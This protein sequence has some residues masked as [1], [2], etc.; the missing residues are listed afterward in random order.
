MMTDKLKT[1]LKRIMIAIVVVGAAT[2]G[3]LYYRRSTKPA[4]SA[5]QNFYKVA[6]RKGNI[7]VNV[8]A[9]G[10]VSSASVQ[11][12]VA[13]SSGTLTELKVSEGSQVKK[14]DVIA[15]IDDD[16][17]SQEIQK[18]ENDLKQQNINL[19]K[20]KDSLNDFYIK[21]PADGRVKAIKAKVGEDSGV[22]TK[23]YG[24]LAIIST[25]GKMKLSIKTDDQIS[26][27]I[28]EK[29][30]VTPDGAGS[31]EGT[32]EDKEPGQGNTIVTVTI[33]RDDLAIG[34][35]ASVAKADGTVVG[36]GTLQVNSPVNVSGGNGVISKIYVSENA[37]IKRGSKM[38]KLKDTDVQASIQS[39]NLSINQIKEE[40]ENKKAKLDELEVIA[41]C[42]GIVTALSIKAGDSVQEGKA[43]ATITDPS[44]LQVVAAVDE[45]DIS[46]VQVGQKAVITLNALPDKSFEGSVVKI[47][48]IGNSTNNVT[49][50]DVTV[51]VNNPENIK[52]GMSAN[53]QIQVA[54]KENV[55]LLP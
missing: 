43:I 3:Y 18:L 40:L 38:F 55:L 54:S 6:A 16:T 31:I 19:N 5:Q 22:T 15:V 50:Y 27:D 21:A 44:Q 32:V 39:Q 28:G 29:V 45:L 26:L 33:D 4:V 8:T 10:S 35:N 34:T 37:K 41:P 30:M 48:D 7:E 1:W 12:V 20:M 36:K 14:G 49:T 52:I 11:D 25:D 46:Q 53:V 24:A 17:I 51:A 13:A 2:G 42:D 23:T 47:A 9:S